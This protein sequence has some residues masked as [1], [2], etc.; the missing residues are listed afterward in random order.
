[1]GKK[2]KN[3]ILSLSLA[4]GQADIKLVKQFIFAI[5]QHS[6]LVINAILQQHFYGWGYFVN[7]MCKNPAAFDLT[8]CGA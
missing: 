2:P 5:I 8:L 3:T 6:L 4:F 7:T 1:M